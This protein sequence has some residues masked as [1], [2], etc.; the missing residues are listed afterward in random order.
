MCVCAIARNIRHVL[1]FIII[2]SPPSGL[3][4][5][6]KG[7]F[8]SSSSTEF[9]AC[10][11]VETTFKVS[12][13][14][15]ATFTFFWDV[16]CNIFETS[17]IPHVPGFFLFLSKNWTCTSRKVSLFLL[18]FYMCFFEKHI[19]HYTCIAISL[20]VFYQAVLFSLK[21]LYPL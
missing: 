16:N 20:T 15:H 3:G 7:N 8:L 5:G 12:T 17:I 6:L 11:S 4:T 14:K 19:I 21:S 1:F 2:L 13:L 10:V 18:V 9:H